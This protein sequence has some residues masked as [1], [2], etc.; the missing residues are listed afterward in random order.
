MFLTIFDLHVTLIHP[1]KF[2]VNFGL[3][4]KE[5]K[6]KIDYQHGCRGHL[7]L[8]TGMIL[9]IFDLQ[10]APLLPIKFQVNWLFGLRRISK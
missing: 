2:H 8:P 10:V 5:K 3:W 6:I 1:M 7:G 4:I 9:A